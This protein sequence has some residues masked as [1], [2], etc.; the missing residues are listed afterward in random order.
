MVS[1][2]LLLLLLLSLFLLI[3]IIFVVILSI[4]ID[5]DPSALHFWKWAFS[6]DYTFLL[7]FLLLLLIMIHPLYTLQTFENELFRQITR[8]RLLLLLLAPLHVFNYWFDFYFFSQ[9]YTPRFAIAA[10]GP[11]T[12]VFIHFIIFYFLLDYTSAIAASG[13]SKC[14]FYS[15]YSFHFFH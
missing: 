12:R 1:L 13:S 3:I 11:S 5:N 9:D 2:L 14:F 6:S 4:I 15:L 8:L 7:L 10:S